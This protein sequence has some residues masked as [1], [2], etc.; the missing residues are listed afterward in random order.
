M[1]WIT[2]FIKE[3]S[4]L[5][6]DC[7]KKS[8]EIF[9]TFK[10]FLIYHIS[11]LI[12][13]KNKS[14]AGRPIKTSLATICDIIFH[15]TDSGIKLT[16]I[17][18]LFGIPKST[19]MRYFKMVSESNC[20]QAIYY[21]LIKLSNK[22]SKLMIVDSFLS[23]S[24]DGTEM[25]GRNPCDRGRRGCKVFIA[26]N[27]QLIAN[28]VHVCGANVSENTCLRKFINDSEN[29]KGVRIL[30]DA[31][32]VGQKVKKEC[33]EK[34]YRLIARPR[35][36]RSGKMTHE[37]TWRDHKEL[38]TKRGGIER[39]IGRI[40]RFKGVTLKSIKSI[41]GYEVLLYVTLIIISSYEIA[42]NL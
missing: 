30:A 37:I 15:M 1:I 26:C 34:G 13:L 3:V 42:K 31:G 9:D 5:K 29:V 38:T 20:L 40:R 12:S 33:K 39:L 24:I 7:Y 25:T 2:K 35:K 8:K 11:S 36:T 10:P 28:H 17:K 16:S 18:E 22:T 23:K 27:E 14:N 32:Y 21:D 4:E 19:F 41:K 6:L